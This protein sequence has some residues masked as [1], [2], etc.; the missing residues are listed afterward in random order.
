MVSQ[1]FRAQRL[2]MAGLLKHARLDS[3]DA[4]QSSIAYFLV[5][6]VVLN[7]LLDTHLLNVLSD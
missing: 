1:I 5:L 2:W 7:R 3:S 6:G 4:L